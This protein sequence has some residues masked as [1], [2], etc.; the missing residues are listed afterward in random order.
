MI[1]EAHLSPEDRRAALEADARDGLVASPKRLSP[2]WFYDERG[3]ALFDEITRLPEY[4]PTRCERALLQAHAAEIAE[5]TGADTLVELGSGTSDKTRVLLDVLRPDRYVPLD[6]DAD[7][8]AQ[9][10]T[11]LYDEYPSLEVHALAADFHRHLDRLPAGGRRL[12]AFL[13]G[14]IGNLRPDERAGFLADMRACL[15]ADDWLLLGADLV[16]DV[17]RLEAAYDDPTGVTAA[18]NRNALEVVNRE[19]DADFDPARFEHVAR[20]VPEADWIE[21][22]LRARMAHKVTI[23]ALDLVIA[24]EEGEELLTE[25]SAKFA[26]DGLAGELA[27]AGLDVVRAWVHGDDDFTLVRARPC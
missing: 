4:Y 13:G 7:T 22:R 1:V 12:V 17:A 18:F 25:I 11:A 6:V 14:T 20:W 21:M 19:L 23:G 5:L 24:F 2:V 27:A 8:L 16:K 26:V 15:G 10:A 9:A 3:S